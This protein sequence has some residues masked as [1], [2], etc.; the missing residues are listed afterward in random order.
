[1]RAKVVSFTRLVKPTYLPSPIARIPNTAARTEQPIC[2]TDSTPT[3]DANPPRT[4]A[5]H[6]CPVLLA[7]ADAS[8]LD[9]SAQQVEIERTPEIV[10]MQ[11]IQKKQG[12]LFMK[13][14]YGLALVLRLLSLLSN[15]GLFN[16]L[17]GKRA[18][19]LS[20]GVVPVRLTV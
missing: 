17:M 1:M 5:N 18:K 15:M 10:A 16:L 12:D 7:G 14:G 11:A 4:R 20:H 6:L 19:A 2:A 8:T 13:A 9:A 3:Q